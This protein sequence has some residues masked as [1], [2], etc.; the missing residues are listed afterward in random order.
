MYVCIYIE[1]ERESEE[2]VV[3]EKPADI[4]LNPL[5]NEVNVVSV[6]QEI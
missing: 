4:I 2:G 6:L 1:R 5:P 3:G